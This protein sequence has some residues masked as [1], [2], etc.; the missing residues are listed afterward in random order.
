MILALIAVDIGSVATRIDF[1]SYKLMR[2]ERKTD[3]VNLTHSNER[4][5]PLWPTYRIRISVKD[6]M[7]ETL[8][9]YIFV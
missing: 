3:G 4:Q 2:H 1:T 5:V 8:L 7:I 6:S 9:V